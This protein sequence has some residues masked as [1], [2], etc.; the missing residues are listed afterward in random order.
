MV[1]RWVLVTVILSSGFAQTS[2]PELQQRTAAVRSSTTRGGEARRADILWIIEHHPEAAVLQEPI[3]TIA[4]E[5]DPE[6]YARA[7][8]LWQ[9]VTKQDDTPLAV[10]SN[11]AAFFI[12]SDPHFALDL[13]RRARALDASNVMWPARM[14][15]VYA[16]AI[17]GISAVNRNGLPMAAKQDPAAVEK[18]MSEL[19]ASTDAAVIASAATA[20]GMPMRVITVTGR[21]TRKASALST[22]PRSVSR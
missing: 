4:P 8:A 20:I 13:L 7:R 12:S 22:P 21:S 5:A 1:T 6:G 16:F 3:F 2:D 19:L 9:K 15:Q 17:T 18:W 14:G 10:L 11:A